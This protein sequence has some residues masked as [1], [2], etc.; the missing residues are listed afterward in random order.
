MDFGIGNL[1]S[2][3]THS[4]VGLNFHEMYFEI[5]NTSR[6]VI[7]KNTRSKDMNLVRNPGW[8]E[9]ELSWNPHDH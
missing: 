9:R 6:V 7:L 8:N 5:V 1:V 2:L 4:S 3:Y